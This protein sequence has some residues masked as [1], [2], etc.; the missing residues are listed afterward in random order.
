MADQSLEYLLIVEQEKA[1]RLLDL[2]R[3][4]QELLELSE[5]YIPGDLFYRDNLHD[6]LAKELAD[7]KS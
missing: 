1:S 5:K 7:A 6:E 3:R 2:L 4:C